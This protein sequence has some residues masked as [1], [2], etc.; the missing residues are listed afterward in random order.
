MR[1]ICVL[2]LCMALATIFSACGR[3]SDADLAA[4][5][6]SAMD[7]AEGWYEADVPRMDSALAE[8]FVKR[9]IANPKEKSRVENLTKMDMVAYTRQGGGNKKDRKSYRIEYKLLEKSEN[10]ASAVVFSEYVDY[11]HLARIEGEW[12]IVNVLWDYGKK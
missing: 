3:G 6:K 1:N 9:R 12:K 2:G 4:I 11:L 8:D 10:I 5:K 7:Y